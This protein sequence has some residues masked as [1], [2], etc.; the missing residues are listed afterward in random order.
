MSTST[1]CQAQDSILAPLL[2]TAKEAA[3]AC[4]LSPASWHRLTSSRKNPAAVRIGGIVRWRRS[5]IEEWVV[6]GCPD[7]DTLGMLRAESVR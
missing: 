5:D 3:R 4:G 2:L 1:D 6:A 7:R